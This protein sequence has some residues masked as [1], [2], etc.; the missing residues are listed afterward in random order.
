M[1]DSVGTCFRYSVV[2]VVAVVYF[3]VVIQSK[4]TSV[5]VKSLDNL[6]DYTIQICKCAS[7]EF[8]QKLLKIWQYLFVYSLI[9]VNIWLSLCLRRNKINTWLVSPE[10]KQWNKQVRHAQ[11]KL[12]VFV[13]KKNNIFTFWFYFFF[14]FESI[15]VFSKYFFLNLK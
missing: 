3:A 6:C 4:L 14:N 9:K 15:F 8:W 10:V 13:L 11:S 7:C 12:K 2:V 1:T 5:Q